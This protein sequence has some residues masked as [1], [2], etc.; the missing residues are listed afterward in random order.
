M[1]AGVAVL[2]NL[3]EFL[4]VRRVPANDSVAGPPI[5]RETAALNEP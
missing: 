4:A 3:F 5:E 2:L 1:L